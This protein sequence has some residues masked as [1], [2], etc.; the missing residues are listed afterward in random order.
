[1]NDVFD[2]WKLGAMLLDIVIGFG[3]PLSLAMLF[4]KKY[5]VR[6]SVLILG[7]GTFIIVNIVFCGIVDGL[8]DYAYDAIGLGNSNKSLA[9]VHGLFRGLVQLAGYYFSTKICLREHER[10][11]NALMFGLGLSIFY[12]FYYNVI[13]GFSN[14]LTATQINEW[15]VSDYLS[16]FE[17]EVR[18]EAESTINNLIDMS[19]FEIVEGLIFAILIF[20]VLFSASILIFEA[21][22][23]SGKNYLLPTIGTVLAITNIIICY[24]NIDII[25]GVVYLVLIGILSAIACFVAYIFYGADKESKRGKADI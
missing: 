25:S 23:R 8:I 6:I 12:F 4:R 24:R 1:M 22:K 20:G 9:L 17:G 18:A 5:K 2:T 16:R 19:V 14:F 10:K 15:G 7:L 3:L 11:E 21:V 13:G